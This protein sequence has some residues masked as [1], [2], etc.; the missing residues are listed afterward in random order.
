[1]PGLLFDYHI[2]PKCLDRLPVSY[3]V[4][5]GQPAP[6]KAVRSGFAMFD[7][8]TIHSTTDL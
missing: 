6:E 1:M 2:Y 3:S 7:I 4:N 8:I 5:Q